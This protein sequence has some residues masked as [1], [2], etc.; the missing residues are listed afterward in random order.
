MDENSLLAA[1]LRYAAAGVHV[2]PCRIAIRGDGKKDPIIP[3]PW[4]QLSTTDTAT[5]AAWF[6]DGRPYANGAIVID[7]GKS[8]IVG[9]DQDVTEGKNGIVEWEKLD[10]TPTWRVRS[11][12]GGAHDYYRADPEHPF[13]VD[14]TGVVAD[15]VDV[16]S[17]G[18]FLFA[19]PSI[20]PRGGSWEWVAS[21]PDWPNL[22]PVPPVVIERMEAHASNR[23]A[24]KRTAS[25]SPLAVSGEVMAPRVG[26]GWELFGGGQQ[27][28]RDF[29]PDG[30]YKTRAAAI[31]LLQKDHREFV[32]LTTEGSA[33]SHF[34][35]QVYGVK[36]GY[37]VGVF[38]SY[39]W[40]LGVLMGA[41][42]ENGF[43]DANGYAYA[44]G[45]AERGL[46]HGMKTPWIEQSTP[47]QQ[48][49]AAIA[50]QP[51]GTDPVEALLAEMLQPGEI[52]NRPP[53]R[54]MIHGYLQFDS[55]SWII[56]PP[57]SMK[58]FIVL[59]MAA[60]VARGEPW[61][62]RRTN[63]ADV[64]M[65]VAEGAGGVGKRIKAWEK[66]NGAIGEGRMFIL[67]RPV[68]AGQPGAWAV[69]V[70]A[71]RR[72]AASA[73]ERGRGTFVI[74]DTQA[75]VTVG[76][77]ENDATDMG[78]FVGALSAIREATG[79]CV[80]PVHHTGR[81]G[82][83]ARGSSA[84]DG[85][86]TTE[87]KV[88]PGKGKLAAKLIVEKQKDIEEIEPMRLGFEVV[89]VGQDEDGMPL[90][91]LVLA[92]QD[93]LAFKLAWEEAEA[94]QGE[95]A[96][97][98]PLKDRVTLDS[99]IER[100]REP[101]GQ[102]PVNEWW[103]VQAMVDTAET[104]GLTQADVKGIVEEKRG[105]ID[106]QTFKRAWQKVT[107]DG[108]RWSDVIVKANGERWTVDRVAIAGLDQD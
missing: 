88:M 107:E 51:D 18:G 44:R 105:T 36:A 93:S 65:I 8:G 14:N 98:A 81:A 29:G 54:Y 86:Q 62:G 68:Q 56:G 76:L 4:K 35:A 89:D 60:R 77:K 11:P 16:R 24:R 19:P 74:L 30:G 85:A 45:Q 96:S 3:G 47:E 72:L 27:D 42:E 37:G 46:A 94:G 69:L 41:C 78:V 95:T 91:S 103:I 21:E 61:Q 100:R 20:D 2:F 5:I 17:L 13:T 106:K 40:A 79:A 48:A 39:E 90:T 49:E 23:S 43:A 12:T 57:G 31:E 104:L 53:P 9:I 32:S 6:G 97:E 55:E 87:L 58:S 80:L 83:D 67:P 73:R 75:R 63:P 70:E 64:V 92:D 38:W 108:G 22:P 1:A 15:G 10:P 82:G 59:D 34:L 7:C 99:W 71:C 26:G 102:A 101:R 84:I 50:V 28:G 66:R 25:P 33:R 52:V